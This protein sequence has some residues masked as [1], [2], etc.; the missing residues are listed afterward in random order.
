MKKV[1]PPFHVSLPK[2]NLKVCPDVVPKEKK[3]CNCKK[4]TSRNPRK[5]KKRKRRRKIYK[6]D[7]NKQERRKKKE[8]RKKKK[9][10]KES[11]FW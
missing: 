4:F 7:R 2:R 1:F 10:R 9:Q 5:K 8:E 6:K 11:R 3:K